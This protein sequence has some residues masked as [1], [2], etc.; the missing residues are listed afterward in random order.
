[1]TFRLWRC[2]LHSLRKD[3]LSNMIIYPYITSKKIS[4]VFLTNIVV[5]AT[6]TILCTEESW[7]GITGC[8]AGWMI[9]I[10]LY[11]S[12]RRMREKSSTYPRNY[13]LKCILQM[14]WLD[15]ILK[16]KQSNILG[17]QVQKSICKMLASLFPPPIRRR[18]ESVFFNKNASSRIRSAR[19][20]SSLSWCTNDALR[21]H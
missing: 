3:K 15:L 4:K 12:Q 9:L 21:M 6:A 14:F 19:L 2:F 5:S 8:S 7:V 11:Q 10:T 16:I 18:K 20:K 13:L 1:M 17:Q